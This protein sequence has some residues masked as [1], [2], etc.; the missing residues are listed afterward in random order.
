MVLPGPMCQAVTA[1]VRKKIRDYRP[2]WQSVGEPPG[3]FTTPCKTV[4]RRYCCAVISGSSSQKPSCGSW[5]S[6]GI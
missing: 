3:F 1:I 2:I 4:F 6:R 5:A